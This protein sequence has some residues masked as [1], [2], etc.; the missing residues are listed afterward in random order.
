LRD[1]LPDGLIAL[2]AELDLEEIMRLIERTA[3]WVDPDTFQLLP[4]WYPEYSRAAFFYKSNWSE[5]QLNTNRQTKQSVHKQEGNLYANKALTHALGL[6]SDVRPNWSCCHIWGVD[7]SLYQETNAIAQDPKFYSCVANMVLLP[8]PLKAF[9]DVS[10]VKAMLRICAQYLYG[11]RCEHESLAESISIVESW[12]SWDAFPASWPNP[13]RKSATPLGVTRLNDSIRRDVE[14]RL[15]RIRSDLVSAGA[16][17][18]R[19]SVRSV[20]SHWRISL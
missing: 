20:L 5:P 4:V 2:R 15:E 19:E 9:T 8:T 14:R 13:L 12:S 18:P 7:D 6:R 1:S 10:E 3:R 17:Y 16:Y 11:W